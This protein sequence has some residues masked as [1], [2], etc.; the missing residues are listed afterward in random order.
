MTA[1]ISK[2]RKDLQNKNFVPMPGRRNLFEKPMGPSRVKEDGEIREVFHC[3]KCDKEIKVET[4]DL[5]PTTGSHNHKVLEA[6]CTN[7][8]QMMFKVCPTKT[9]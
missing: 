6:K 4:K 3:L 1:N 9:H 7:C 5:I 8:G 2:I